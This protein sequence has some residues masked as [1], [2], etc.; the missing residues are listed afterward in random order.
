V[1]DKNNGLFRQKELDGF[2]FPLRFQ[3]AQIYTAGNRNAV[4]ILPLPNHLVLPSLH[5]PIKKSEN[6]PAEQTL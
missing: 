1:S 2:R 3:A 6:L 5:L 4:P